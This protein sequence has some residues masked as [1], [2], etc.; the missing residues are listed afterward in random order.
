[1][2]NGLHPGLHRHRSFRGKHLYKEAT[3]QGGNVLFCSIGNGDFIQTREDKDVMAVTSKLRQIIMCLLIVHDDRRL[4][5]VS[6]AGPRVGAP[7]GPRA[8][9]GWMRQRV[10]PET[11]E[12]LLQKQGRHK[13]KERHE[14]G[15]DG[16]VGSGSNPDRSAL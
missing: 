4:V 12:T 10:K 6:G 3:L 5:L 7:D 1:M 2:K 9:E 11:W 14:S 16:C 13:K 8:S 15:Q